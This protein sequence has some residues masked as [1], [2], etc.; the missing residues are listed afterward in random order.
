M[1]V[2]AIDRDSIAATW[3][4]IAPHIRRTPL[5]EVD[6]GD[7]GLA[8]GPLVLKLEYLQHSGSF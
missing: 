7:F 1:S 8:P 5:L 6:A 2:T 4:A 3:E